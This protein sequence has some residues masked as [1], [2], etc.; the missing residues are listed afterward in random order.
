MSLVE[1]DLSVLLCD[2]IEAARAII[3]TPNLL[4]TDERW[5]RETEWLAARL[6]FPD[7]PGPSI[8]YG[9][10]I[11]RLSHSVLQTH[12]RCSVLGVD[13]SPSM[14]HM[15]DTEV[16]DAGRFT[17][18]TPT[19]LCT[20]MRAGLR[21]R[22]AFA[23]WTLQHLHPHDL[24]MMVAMLHDVLEPHAPLWTIDTPLR[25]VPARMGTQL[26]WVQ[27]DI[28]VKDT[29]AKALTLEDEVKMT[30]EL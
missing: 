20:L 13:I 24:P 6:K 2:T 1:Y 30:A 27:D 29:L 18:I 16:A 17:A 25:F 4:S 12:P 7:E 8:D 10:G 21:A 11:G 9:C 15:A 14:R 3:L 26:G 28:S 5:Q 22:G 19:M 23:V